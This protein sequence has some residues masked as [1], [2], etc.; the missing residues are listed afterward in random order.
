MQVND[1]GNYSGL[2]LVTRLISMIKDFPIDFIGTNL[3]NEFYI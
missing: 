2:R 1:D 3:M